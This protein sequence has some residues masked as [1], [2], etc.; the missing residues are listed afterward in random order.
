M[1]VYVSDLY[2]MLSRCIARCL[3]AVNC[4]ITQSAMFIRGAYRVPDSRGD[5]EKVG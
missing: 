1:F 4:A 5:Y 2:I 3:P